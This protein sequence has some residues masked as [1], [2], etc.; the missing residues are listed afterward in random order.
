[1]QRVRLHFLDDFGPIAD[2]A[3]V[4]DL[5][6]LPAA[7]ITLHLDLLEDA[8]RELM[9]LNDGAPPLT[10]RA[11]IDLPVRGPRTLALLADLLFFNREIVL[12]ARVEIPQRDRHPGFHVWPPPLP[13]L[14][15]SPEMPRSAEE[16][17]EEVEWVVA[18]RATAA[19]L[20]VLRQ[21]FVA[22]LVVDLAGFGLG[23]CVV[24]FGDGDE[25]LG[26]GLVAPVMNEGRVSCEWSFWVREKKI[27]GLKSMRGECLRIM[28][29]RIW[30]L[31]T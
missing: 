24:G 31:V 21:P 7:P 13:G 6:P 12:G 26:G 30:N 11:G 8:R 28:S 23:E 16:A 18:P 25:F 2:G 9:F 20:L 10:L 4:P 15:L 22:V 17:R 14:V 27:G 29:R 19:A 3:L 1:M 5:L